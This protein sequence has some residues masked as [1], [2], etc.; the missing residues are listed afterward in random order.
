MFER[1]QRAT[2]SLNFT[3]LQR[4]LKADEALPQLPG[5]AAQLMACN[6]EM[7]RQRVENI[8]PTDEMNIWVDADDDLDD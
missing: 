5:L 4:R 3:Q 6:T 1:R 2:E 7:K 8:E